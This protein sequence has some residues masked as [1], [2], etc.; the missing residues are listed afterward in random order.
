MTIEF[1]DLD[2]CVEA[3]LARVGKR[4]VLGLP[5]GIGKPN[6]LVN[7]FVARAVADS[8][9]RLT[10]FT[11]LSL[12]AP[13]WRSDL[14]RRFLQPF[15]ER[16]FGAYPELEYVRLLEAG[17]LPDNIEVNEFFLEP[18]AWLGNAH[19]QQN[20]LSANYTHVARDL[21]DRG[22]NVIAQWI[23]DSG[24]GHT[25]SL[26]S[27]PDLTVDLLPHIERMR[28]V[29]QAFALIGC[30][31][32]ELP[33][34]F[35]DA[36]VP[37]S[38]FDFIVGGTTQCPLFCPPNLPIGTTDY[39]IALHIAALVRDGGTLQLGIGELG[40]AIVYGLKL[41]HQFPSDFRALLEAAGALKTGRALIEA[42]GGMQPFGRGVY[43]CSEM[44]V[45]GFIDLYRMGI[46][47]RKVYPHAKLQELLDE[48]RIGEEVSVATLDA[49]HE[50]GVQEIGAR[51]FDSLRDAGVFRDDVRFADGSIVAPDGEPLS[52]TLRRKE[53]RDALSR[54]LGR[55]LRNGVLAHG[56]FFF[57]PKG[58]YATL[59]ELPEAERRLFAM[60][61]ISFINEL[62][63]A[64]QQLK[65]AQRRHARFVNT[66]MMVTGLGAAV[67]D[68]LA[69]GRVVSGVGGQYNFVSMAHALPEARSILC[70]RS[71][72]TAQGIATSNIVWSYGHTTIPRHL[73]DIVV[74]E[75]GIAN[76]RG[77]TDSEIVEALVCVMDARF[78]DEF[79]AQARSAGKL[80]KN[81][82]IPID[83][84]ANT[85]ARLEE[86]LR[87]Y[88]SR[89]LFGELPFGSDFTA[90][91]LVIAK[92]LKRLQAQTAHFGGKL[93]TLAK[94]LSSSRTDAE[95]ERR[96]ARL[97]LER[98][99]S[100]D[101]YVKRGLVRMALR[102]VN[103]KT[104]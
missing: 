20:Y 64:D 79:V 47:K 46:L 57:G 40:D 21:V 35:G 28:A 104:G 70:V 62:Y 56:G 11:A 48:Q 63:G 83:A 8:S 37:R 94:A 27:N 60:Q 55:T 4:I 67:S 24:D 84:R 44:L 51:E 97:G 77:R 88:R 18:G 87:P 34:M 75:Y 36:R 85:P 68:G 6:P 12:R 91:E 54:C 33:F 59:R 86:L 99:T 31:H 81:Y 101:E 69:D 16:V 95:T 61:R 26:S 90:D 80:S 71:T 66:T 29:G 52:A 1:N 103:Q 38:V 23:A 32:S 82:R 45:D 74:T 96:L 30:V 9:I 41:R 42:E 100:I 2:A 15:V 5:V 73:R 93:A 19:L 17:T 65:I 50:A 3:T 49:L 43:G 7:A 92:A 10:I 72:R 13:R 102:Q 22:V 76:L 14:E 25:V 58:F 39:M 78:Q 53:T 98:P 89:G